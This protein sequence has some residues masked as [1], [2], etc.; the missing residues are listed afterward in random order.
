MGASVAVFPLLRPDTVTHAKPVGR[1]VHHDSEE[2]KMSKLDV[3]GLLEAMT[4]D[5]KISLLDGEDFWH[6][7]S[8]PE[9][10]LPS[11]MVSDGPHGLRRQAGESDHLGLKESVPATCFPPAAGLASSW[12][13][14]LVESVGQALGVEAQ[15][16]GVSVLLGPGVNMKRSPLCGRNFEYYSEDP[17]LAGTLGTAFVRGVQSQG[18]GTS[19]KHFAVNNQETDRM[20]VS[21]EVD[22]RTL[23]EIYLPAFEQVVRT[24]QPW[25]V[26]CS[27]NRINGTYASESRELLTQ[28]LREEWG[29]EGLVVSDWGAVNRRDEGVLAGLDL[30]MPSS[31]GAGAE[32]VRRAFDAGRIAEEDIDRAVTRVLELVERSSEGARPGTTFNEDDHHALALRAAQ[33]SAVLLK[34][35]GEVLPVSPDDGGTLAVIGEFARTA[36]YQGAGSSQVNPTRLSN[37]WDSLRSRIGE[38]RSTTFAPGYHIESDEVDPELLAQAVATASEAETVLLFVGLPPAYESEG[39]DRTHMSLPEGQIELIRAVAEANDRTVVVLSN[40][41]VVE[42]S[43]WEDRVPTIL[44]GWLLGQA[45]G[46]AIAS[47]LVGDANPSGRL[48]ETMPVDLRNNPCVGNFPGEHGRVHY[49]EGLLI[50]YRWYDTRRTEVSFPFGHG[51]TYTDFT[52]DGIRVEVVDDGAEPDVEVRVE[53]T[54]VGA[55]HGSEVVQV[56]VHDPVSSVFRP[57]HELRGFERVDLDPGESREVVIHLGSRAF[58]FWHDTLHRWVVEPGEYKLRVG[59]SS[60]DIHAEVSVV[61]SGEEVSPRLGVDATFEEWISRPRLREWVIEAIAGNSFEEQ[62]FDPVNGRM[63]RAIPVVRLTRFPGFPFSEEEAEEAL[64]LLQD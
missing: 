63:M 64:G 20:S 14:D 27:Y 17:L 52:L 38:R 26:M 33:E 35:E 61:L 30:E 42:V 29:F 58:A 6:T 54:N 8:L 19:L 16:Q 36:R 34:N 44:E 18:V 9:L 10:G 57:E 55:V 23:R 22:E 12:D 32:V 4:I 5:Q 1:G 7:R 15:A 24:A 41:S 62:L 53:V 60:R 39:Y 3:P 56:Y 43:E 59:V 49:G 37:A 11:I 21:A 28:I 51:L 13:P 50:G 45:G 47:L 25:T 2:V 40:G 46:E 48:A 31:G